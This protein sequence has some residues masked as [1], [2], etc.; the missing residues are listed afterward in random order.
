MDDVQYKRIYD[1]AKKFAERYRF[2]DESSDFAQEYAI[3]CYELGYEKKLEWFLNDYSDKFRASK[4]VLSSPSGYLSK[5]LSISLDEP[6]GNE[7]DDGATISDLI[8]VCGY[9][10]ECVG[11]LELANECLELILDLIKNPRIRGE[12]RNLYFKYLREAV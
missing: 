8:G 11:N 6:I 12:I 3:K 4:R 9:D 10:V 2:G 1:K 5:N 7:S